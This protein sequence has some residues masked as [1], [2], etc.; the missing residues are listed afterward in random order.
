MLA[1]NPVW[2]LGNHPAC[3]PLP[4]VPLRSARRQGLFA[5]RLRKRRELPSNAQAAKRPCPRSNRNPRTAPPDLAPRAEPLPI[6]SVRRVFL[7]TATAAFRPQ[8]SLGTP[9]PTARSHPPKVRALSLRVARHGKQ[10][11]VFR[12]LPALF[13]LCAFD[14]QH[15]SLFRIVH[16]RRGILRIDAHDDQ[17]MSGLSF[18]F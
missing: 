3:I 4:L 18:A 8:V 6:F 16:K 5:S 1:A 11:P 15:A 14:P 13:E 10:R 9:L 2:R 17:V 7:R 12:A